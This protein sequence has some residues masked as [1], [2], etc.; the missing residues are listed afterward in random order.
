MVNKKT[1][2]ALNGAIVGGRGLGEGEVDNTL[3][4]PKMNVLQS[5]RG[6]KGKAYTAMGA[7][8]V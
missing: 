4:I 5:D 1:K 3:I 8:V 7:Y 2:P 6:H